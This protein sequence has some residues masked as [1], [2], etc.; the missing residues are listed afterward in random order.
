M[1]IK[2]HMNL[3]GMEVQDKVTKIKGVVTS[4]CFDLYGCIQVTITPTAKKNER[5]ESYWYDINRLKILN[6][7]SVIKRPNFEFGSQAKGEQGGFDK[8]SI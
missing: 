8:P 4:L 3:L 2:K 5:T 1:E 6:K 7:K